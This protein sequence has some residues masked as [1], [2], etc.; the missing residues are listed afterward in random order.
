MNR[1]TMGRFPIDWPSI[2]SWNWGIYRLQTPQIIRYA[3]FLSWN[4]KVRNYRLSFTGA[5][6]RH[7]FLSK[8]QPVQVLQGPSYC[9][10]MM[11]R[12]HRTP[13][14]QEIAFQGIYISK[15]SQGSMLP[16]PLEVRSR[17]S[18]QSR[19]IIPI[20]PYESAKLKN[21]IKTMYYN[22]N[23]CIIYNFK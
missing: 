5:E 21:W 1:D 20:R 7:L 12:G 19:Q 22:D 10:S 3:R 23:N 17:A 9:S 16:H 4:W 13:R 15:F 14:M 8:H 11:P 2:R 6:N 18:G